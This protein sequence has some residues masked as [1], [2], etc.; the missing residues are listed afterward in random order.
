MKTIH[1]TIKDA[2]CSLTLLL[3][4]CNFKKSDCQVYADD[5]LK[6][7]HGK[8]Y[9]ADREKGTILGISDYERDKE[10]SGVYYFFPNGRLKSYK[11]FETDSA[12]DYSEDYDQ[13][14]QLINMTGRPLVDVAIREVDGDS[15]VISYHLF[16]LNKTFENA[17]LTVNTNTPVNVRLTDDTLYSNMKRTSI[18]INTKKLI[19]FRVY[20]SCDYLINCTA[21][22][23]RLDDT[24]SLVKNPRLNL[25]Q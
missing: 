3:F 15:A 24:L 8:V 21:K 5:I 11:F 14:G 18:G 10:K 1:F 12:Y 2:V 4:S 20:F 22:K 23:L 7:N 25:E 9:V 16:S 13:D 6:S 19:R 17:R